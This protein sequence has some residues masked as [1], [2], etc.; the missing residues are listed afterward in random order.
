VLP[1]AISCGKVYFIRSCFPL[2]RTFRQLDH[3][4]FKINPGGSLATPLI[5]IN[6]TDNQAM[7]RIFFIK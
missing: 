4:P 7:D 5:N 2:V 6:K 3:L 1:E